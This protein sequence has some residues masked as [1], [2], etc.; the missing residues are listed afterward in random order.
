MMIHGDLIMVI[1]G[2]VWECMVMYGD[3]VWRMVLCILNGDLGYNLK[4]FSSN[5]HTPR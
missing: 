1:Y 3:L 4:A 5:Q 2:D